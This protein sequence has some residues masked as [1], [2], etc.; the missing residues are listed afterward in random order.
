MA[1]ILFLLDLFNTFL[2]PTPK[3]LGFCIKMS[4][5]F[6]CFHHTKYISCSRDVHDVI[7]IGKCIEEYLINIIAI[8]C[9]QSLIL[10]IVVLNVFLSTLLRNIPNCNAVIKSAFGKQTIFTVIQEVLFND[11]IIILVHIMYSS[12]L[13]N[14][15]HCIIN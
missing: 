10:F 5:K 4:H 8:N 12:S 13:F 9:I 11:F 7:S 2:Q 6:H 15:H 14:W 3:T 1:H